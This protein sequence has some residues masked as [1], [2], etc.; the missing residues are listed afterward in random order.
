MSRRSLRF[1]ALTAALLLATGGAFSGAALGQETTTTPAPTTTPETSTT[2]PET[3]M[4]SPAEVEP[5][6]DLSISVK[7]DRDRYALPDLVHATVTLANVGTVVAEEVHIF[8]SGLKLTDADWGDYMRQL[9]PGASKVFEVNGLI[10]GYTRGRFEVHAGAW[11]SG[12]DANPA[13]NV[14]STSAAVTGVSGHVAGLVYGDRNH[15]GKPD[16]GEALAGAVVHL[17]GGMPF[18]RVSTTTGVDGRFAFDD[19]N[20]GEYEASYHLPGGWTVYGGPEVFSVT[21]D[22]D[23]PVE[24]SVPGS[25]TMTEVL[26]VSMALDKDVYTFG[27]PVRLD[28]TLTNHTAWDV[29]GVNVQCVEREYYLMP[30]NP[31]WGVFSP[32]GPGATVPA[33]QSVTISITDVVRDGAR[34]Y[35]ELGVLCRFA[36]GDGW[37]GRVEATDT[38]RVQGGIGALEGILAGYDRPHFQVTGPP[39]SPI[40]Q[41]KIVFIERATKRIAGSVITDAHGHFTIGG[42]AAG[43]YQPVIVGPWKTSTTVHVKADI[44]SSAYIYAQWGPDVPDPETTTP[45]Q[46]PGGGGGTP[47]DESDNELAYTGASVI[48]LSIAGLVTVLVGLVVLIASR[49]RRTT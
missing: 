46:P 24:L 44:T 6:P 23:K 40:P 19:L 42:L 48:G 4:E 22:V 38:A 3:P 18:D 34:V 17:D 29:T 11:F 28:V 30:A 20:P 33:G 16:P 32:G 31:G 9:E 12:A 35:G 45:P 41:T 5:L 21:V 43:E 36:P 10:D 7:L 13:D 39:P 15:D 14:A 2:A 25:R 26:A 37:E 8:I 49:R 47:P 27:D 1:S